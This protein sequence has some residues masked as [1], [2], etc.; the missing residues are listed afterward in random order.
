MGALMLFTDT[1]VKYFT[2]C[3]LSAVG[4][5]AEYQNLFV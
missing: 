5:M 2:G 3:W 4:H 1:F